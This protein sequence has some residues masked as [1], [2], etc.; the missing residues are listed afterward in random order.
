MEQIAE[1]IISDIEN[2]D[3][4][5]EAQVIESKHSRRGGPGFNALPSTTNN[6]KDPITSY[7][8]TSLSK[9]MGQKS[10]L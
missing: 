5:N 4:H 8:N 6:N 7:S 9:I 10:F 1:S 2:E 3:D